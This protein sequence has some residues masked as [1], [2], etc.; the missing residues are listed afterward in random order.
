M[1]DYRWGSLDRRQLHIRT[2]VP[3]C[4][5]VPTPHGWKFSLCKALSPRNL[6][7]AIFNRHHWG[8]RAK[9]HIGINH[10]CYC[11]AGSSIDGRIELAGYGF[12]F[13]YSNFSGG[14]VPCWCDKA[15]EEL[16]ERDH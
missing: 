8:I 5:R 1:A 4:A 16:R 9:R 6:I 7:R 2:L 3:W 10:R 12:I 13:W 11:D 15:L 14:E